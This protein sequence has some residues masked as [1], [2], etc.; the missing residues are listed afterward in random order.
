[1]NLPVRAVETGRLDQLLLALAEMG[2][3]RYVEPHLRVPIWNPGLSN[4]VQR[5]IASWGVPTDPVQSLQVGQIRVPLAFF[6]AWARAAKLLP[7][8]GGGR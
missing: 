4:F 5:R 6:E 3:R 7:P 2:V 8:A 1:M